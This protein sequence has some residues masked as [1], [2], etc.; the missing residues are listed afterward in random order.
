MAVLVATPLLPNFYICRAPSGLD[1]MV[2]HAR[3]GMGWPGVRSRHVELGWHEAGPGWHRAQLEWSRPN[4]AHQ[5][6]KDLACRPVLHHSPDLQGQ[7]VEHHCPRACIYLCT[8][9]KLVCFCL[10]CLREQMATYTLGRHP[11]GFCSTYQ[12][13]ALWKT[14]NWDWRIPK[15]G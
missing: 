9:G 14:G 8:C 5:P 4:P 2:L 6:L 12:V 7:K 1:S 3:L 13:G 15:P 11:S 10:Q